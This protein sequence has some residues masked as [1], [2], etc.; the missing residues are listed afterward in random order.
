MK[1]VFVLGLRRYRQLNEWD[2][3]MQRLEQQHAFLTSSHQLV[4]YAGTAE[5]ARVPFS[6]C[7]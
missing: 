4:S 2:A 3:D 1:L 7:E 5:Q 6:T